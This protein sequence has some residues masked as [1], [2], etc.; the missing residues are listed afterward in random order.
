M[1][2]K[3]LYL[4]LVVIL[5]STMTFAKSKISGEYYDWTK[6]MQPERPWVRDYNKTIISKLFLCERTPDNK[7]KKV[8]QTFAQALET[9]KRYDAI[10]C[11]IPKIIYLVGWNHQGHDSGY[12]DFSVVNDALKCSGMS[13]TESLRW[14]MRE[15]KK[16]N[17]TVSL[18][19]NMF[20]A[21]DNSPLWNEYLRKDIIAK[22]KQ[23]NPI[24]GE[25]F[26]GMQSY[27]IS[28]AQEWKMGLTTKRID[29]LL[30][31]LPEL[32]E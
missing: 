27:Q 22:D 24:R 8:H 17:T 20:D 13:A 2:N 29:A 10:T 19:I 5:F 3:A 16:Y 28:Y 18:H 4:S 26:S 21:Y 25:V 6:T 9:I 14:L 7:I 32:I 1:K 15:A 31:L 23:G 30:E 11:D 12:P